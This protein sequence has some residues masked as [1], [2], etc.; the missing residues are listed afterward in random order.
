MIKKMKAFMVWV[1]IAVVGFLG[2]VYVSLVGEE[3]YMTNCV[4][5][6][7]ECE[8]GNIHQLTKKVAGWL[9]K[10]KAEMLDSSNL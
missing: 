10:Q 7:L 8:Q 1:F 4:N 3:N 6:G 9:Q 2:L 5:L